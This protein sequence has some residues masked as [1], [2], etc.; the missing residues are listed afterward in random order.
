[1]KT[2]FGTLKGIPVYKVNRFDSEIAR[3]GCI[4]LVADGDRFWKICTTSSVA[5]GAYDS[6][7]GNTSIYDEEIF[8]ANMRALERMA[9]C[10]EEVKSKPKQPEKNLTEECV[11]CLLPELDGIINC[12]MGSVNATCEDLMNKVEAV[13]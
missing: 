7:V 6:A 9:K 4:Q 10:K 12:I 11:N 13:G 8:N 5:D 3:Q 1:M 2:E